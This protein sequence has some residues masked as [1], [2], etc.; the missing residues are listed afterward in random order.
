M[1]KNLS[2]FAGKTHF[3]QELIR[4]APEIYDTRP[5]PVYYFYRVYQAKFREMPLVHFIEGMCTF[6][7][8]RKNVSPRS[9]ATIIL[10]D[11]GRDMTED[12]SEIFSVGSHHVGC[13]VCLVVHNLFDRNR[14]FRNI[15]LNTRYLVVY[16]NS[17]DASTI[18]NLGKQFDP[19]N[20]RRLVAIYQKATERPFS[21]L[22]LDFDQKTEEDFRLRSNIFFEGG[23]PMVVYQRT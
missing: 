22:F 7:W 21:Y 15:S 13:N 6:E 8:L 1:L 12:T 19:S 2:V 4:K 17:R 18:I 9:N 10:D 23:R 16:K 3:L 5:G 20:V 14:A 11:L